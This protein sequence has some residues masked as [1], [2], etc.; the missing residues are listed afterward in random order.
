MS[1]TQT[2][3]RV[4]GASVHG[5]LRRDHTRWVLET[6]DGERLIGVIVDERNI[7]PKV[8]RLRWWILSKGHIWIDRR[9]AA[10]REAEIRP[11]A[12][13]AIPLRVVNGGLPGLGRRR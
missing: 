12:A 6:T 8:N 13:P 3:K 4:R 2:K 1:Q 9:S 10:E 7:T 5:T 11:L